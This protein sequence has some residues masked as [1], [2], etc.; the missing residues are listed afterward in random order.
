MTAPTIQRATK[1]ATSAGPAAAPLV[2]SPEFLALAGQLDATSYE[3]VTHPIDRPGQ[4]PRYPVPGGQGQ[5]TENV[6]QFYSDSYER[7]G[8]LLAALVSDRS[9]QRLG[10]PELGGL[11][12]PEFTKWVKNK[13]T[14]EGKGRAKIEVVE[15]RRYPL[16]LKSGPTSKTNDLH[17][18]FFSV[19]K[20]KADGRTFEIGKLHRFVVTEPNRGQLQHLTETGVSEK[21]VGARHNQ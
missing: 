1:T 15:S 20:L 18:G 3:N 11:G 4:P 16:L 14:D 2:A 8:E 5:N 19:M 10:A 13:L 6:F 7:A 12:Q 9:D 17:V 21:K